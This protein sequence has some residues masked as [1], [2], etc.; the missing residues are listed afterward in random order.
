MQS[1]SR[2]VSLPHSRLW[3]RCF[4][5]TAAFA[6]LSAGGVV[7]QTRGEEPKPAAK[8]ARKAKA[9]I[10]AK[11][12]QPKVAAAND[13]DDAVAQQMIARYRPI[14]NCELE[15]IRQAC[16]PAPEQRP[17]IKAAGE[18]SLKQ[19]VQQAGNP[20]PVIRVFGQNT[21]ST[22][23]VLRANLRKALTAQLSPEQAASYAKRITER[24]A[25]RKRALILFVVARLDTALYL[26]NQQRDKIG[27]S[28]SAAWQ[29][30]WDE[31]AGV[32]N[33]PGNYLPQL[34]D[35]CVVPHLNTD[36]TAVYSGIQKVNISGSVFIQNNDEAEADDWW[37]SEPAKP[38]EG[39]KPAAAAAAQPSP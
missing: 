37:G 27:D 25:T 39:A 22:D 29:E 28:L 12:P 16:D 31:W 26:T 9:A 4:Q 32:A 8:Q 13:Q 34:P 35:T 14:L 33:Y 21:D 15:L 18:A 5:L 24:T 36:Q 23:T 11:A 17:G 2:Q 7:L 1:M 6:V 38:A 20:G 19:S 10:R 30:A 3:K